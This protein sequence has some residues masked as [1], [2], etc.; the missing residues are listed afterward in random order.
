MFKKKFLFREFIPLLFICGFMVHSDK[1][2]AKAKENSIA[3]KKTKIIIFNSSGGGG[4]EAAT[5]AITSYLEDEFSVKSFYLFKDIL[6]SL[7]PV[8]KI[9]F[10]SSAGEDLYN[11]LIQGKYYQTLNNM[12]YFGEWMFY[13]FHNKITS[14][15]K[16]F[17]KRHKPDLVISVIP[18][19]NRAIL[20]ASK[21][22]NIP[23][24]LIPTDLDL[25]TFLGGMT[26]INYS[27][28]HL[29]LSFDD[30]EIKEPAIKA[31]IL[32]EQ[33]SVI[34]F[35]L[36][37][38]F[39]THKNKAIIKKKYKIPHNKPVVMIVLGAAGS[40]SIYR[41]VKQ[42]STVSIPL[43]LVVVLGRSEYLRSRILEIPLSPSITITIFGTTPHIADLMAISD[44]CITKSGSV[45]FCEAL[46]SDVPIL[47]DATGTILKWEKFNHHFTE[48][49]G[50]G[51][52]IKRYSKAT[53]EIT[54]LL[55]NPHVLN[56]TK[57]KIA[58]IAKPQFSQTIKPLVK[59]MLSLKT[60]K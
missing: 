56:H 13:L 34:G 42:L 37:K 41:Y 6:S 14:I 21:E 27:K 4:H 22:L 25:K 52:L 44:L 53:L 51:Y 18:F 10:G 32:K 30:P 38:D 57:K 35:P 49:H 60:F 55:N 16:N 48:K 47:I 46:Y 5:K 36:R 3:V 19:A 8:K 20:D 7:D 9:S 15:I 12:G 58:H 59:Q 23:F 24:L 50:L 1:I 54:Q 43:H 11:N 31:N 26:D 2:K 33:M 45:S 29:G 39:F 17:L 40:T 28:F